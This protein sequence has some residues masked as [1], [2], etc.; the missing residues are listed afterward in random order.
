M[1]KHILI[2][3]LALGCSTYPVGSP[4]NCDQGVTSIDPDVVASIGLSADDAVAAFPSQWDV[5]WARI[6]R[7]TEAVVPLPD[8]DDVVE[9]NLS[10][11][12]AAEVVS[13]GVCGRPAGAEFLRVQVAGAFST[14]DGLT[15]GDLTGWIEVEDV[16]GLD[17]QFLLDAPEIVL[18]G[19]D[20]A[21]AEQLVMDR[22]RI[23]M[24]EGYR[25]SFVG[26]G[27]LVDP[28]LGLGV[29]AH[30]LGAD[31]SGITSAL[32]HASSLVPR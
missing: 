32:W 4:P 10:T 1:N 11:V 6:D 31:Q 12:S 20:L 28:P 9:V 17:W 19:D 23:A 21:L 25:G 26:Q 13:S 7:Q 8:P 24:T 27:P 14:D 2:A 22:G 5:T 30:G 16:D 18:A 29:D 15:A 3:S